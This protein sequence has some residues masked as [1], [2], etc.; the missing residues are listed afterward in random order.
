MIGGI[1]IGILISAVILAL[2]AAKILKLFW[3]KF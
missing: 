2:I 1:T 3:S